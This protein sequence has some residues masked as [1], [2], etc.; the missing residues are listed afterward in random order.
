MKGVFPLVFNYYF[1]SIPVY[2]S[3]KKKMK[4]N[5]HIPFFFKKKKQNKKKKKK[6]KLITW[7]YDKIVWGVSYVCRQGSR[8]RPRYKEQPMLLKMWRGWT[9]EKGAVAS[10]PLPSCTILPLEHVS[11]WFLKWQNNILQTF[12]FVCQEYWLV[13]LH[14]VPLF[15]WQF[16]VTSIFMLSVLFI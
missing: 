7:G 10:A 1:F 14:S 9:N 2:H 16:S 3:Q 6:R 4:Y 5:C 15:R 12:H 11:A 13:A 8:R